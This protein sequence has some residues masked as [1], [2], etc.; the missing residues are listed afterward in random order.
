MQKVTTQSV[1]DSIKQDFGCSVGLTRED[2]EL[3]AA[4]EH[5][6][7]QRSSDH[8]KKKYICFLRYSGHCGTSNTGRLAYILNPDKKN[9][10]NVI[11]RVHVVVGDETESREMQLTLPPASKLGLSCTKTFST[12]EAALCYTIIKEKLGTDETFA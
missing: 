2:H 3:C 11:L 8:C 1:F 10:Y 7:Q 4:R 9:S 5:S 12:P 6:S